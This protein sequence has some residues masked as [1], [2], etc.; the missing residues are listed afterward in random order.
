MYIVDRYGIRKSP[1]LHPKTVFLSNGSCYPL[2]LQGGYCIVKYC[3]R[4]GAMHI[5]PASYSYFLSRGIQE[6][7]NRAT[8]ISVLYYS[9]HN[10]HHDPFGPP[11]R[12]Q[13]PSTL[14]SIQNGVVN[15]FFNHWRT[16]AISSLPSQSKSLRRKH[17]SMLY[18][19]PYTT[20]PYH[21][22]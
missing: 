3:R 2:S 14:P 18:C 6:P 21:T 10:D 19:T 9:S 7:R 22:C 13:R 15:S 16:T 4:G 11:S 8:E 20:V 5:S 12:D 1:A 17:D